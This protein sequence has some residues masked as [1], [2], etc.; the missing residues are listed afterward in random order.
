MKSYLS[1]PLYFDCFLAAAL[2]FADVFAMDELK[3]RAPDTRRHGEE[4][5]MHNGPQSLRA[6]IDADFW[7]ESVDKLV[8]DTE[9]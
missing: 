7:L 5:T 4:S 1:T 8:S 9:H 6:P 2:H 3:I